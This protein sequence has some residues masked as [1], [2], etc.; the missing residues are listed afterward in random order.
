MCA[1]VVEERKCVMLVRHG[2]LRQYAC[3]GAGYRGRGMV[4]RVLKA[5]KCVNFLRYGQS[6][7]YACSRAGRSGGAAGVMLT[8]HGFVRTHLAVGC[9]AQVILSALRRPARHSGW[10]CALC[11]QGCQRHDSPLLTGSIL[12]SVLWFVS[13]QPTTSRTRTARAGQTPGSLM[14]HSHREGASR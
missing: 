9:W 3:V 2:E 10:A 11:V 1:R 13:L 5:C 6:C 8:C 14:H 12:L 7:Q 4:G